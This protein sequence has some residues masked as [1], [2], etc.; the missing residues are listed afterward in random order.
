MISIW[1]LLNW[2]QVPIKKSLGLWLRIHSWNENSMVSAYSKRWVCKKVS[3]IP[4]IWSPIEIQAFPITFWK[5]IYF[6]LAQSPLSQ[7]A[8]HLAKKDNTSLHH[9][10]K[11]ADKISDQSNS[12]PQN[13]LMSTNEEHCAKKNQIRLHT[14]FCRN[15]VFVRYRQQK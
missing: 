5:S 15:V 7:N 12:L 1:V 8:C 4:T 9:F 6:C 3:Q 13:S 11:F 14:D 10:S 2:F